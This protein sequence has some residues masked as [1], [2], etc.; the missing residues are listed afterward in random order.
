MGAFTSKGVCTPHELDFDLSEYSHGCRGQAE[1]DL[2]LIC[3]D[4]DDKAILASEAR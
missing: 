2:R 4:L 1:S 3:S